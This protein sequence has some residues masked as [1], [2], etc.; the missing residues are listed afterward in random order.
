MKTHTDL[1]N[2]LATTFN[3]K[4]YLEIGVQNPANNFNK[5]KCEIKIGVDPEVDNN[6][7]IKTTSDDFFIDQVEAIEDKT[8]YPYDLILIDGLHHSDQVKR[9]FD[10]SLLCLND[11]GFILIHDTLPTDEMYTHVPRD[12]KIWFGDVYK[13]ALRLQE[14]DS[15]DF[16]TVDF[17]CGCTVVWKDASKKGTPLT[18]EIDWNYYLQNKGALRILSVEE[19]TALHSQVTSI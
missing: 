1:L 10:N 15:I 17:D 5:I 12:T 6:S 9:D 19:F 7:V 4:S 11:N 13:F 16:V 2:F 14:Y 8:D 18:E 3:L